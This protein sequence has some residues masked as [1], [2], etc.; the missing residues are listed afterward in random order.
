MIV[1]FSLKWHRGVAAR[2]SAPSHCRLP[3][4]QGW[5]RE[6]VIPNLSGFSREGAAAGDRRA[7]GVGVLKL[8]I[9]ACGPLTAGRSSM[10]RGFPM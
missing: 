9:V 2:K 3:Q 6:V 5:L 1:E 8:L 10:G 4:D 7:W